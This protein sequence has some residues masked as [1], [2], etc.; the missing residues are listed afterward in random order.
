[1]T[2][3]VQKWIPL[4]ESSVDERTNPAWS[5]TVTTK[6][7]YILPSVRKTLDAF[8]LELRAFTLLV[9]DTEQVIC[10]FL[11]KIS[12]LCFLS[13]ENITEKCLQTKQTIS[14]GHTTWFQ[15]RNKMITTV[16]GHN[17]R[18]QAGLTPSPPSPCAALSLC[19]LDV[20]GTLSY[21]DIDC[22]KWQ[23]RILHT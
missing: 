17:G 6:V 22:C 13:L 20:W 15:E 10:R 14:S 23:P 3:S 2:F 7:H 8:K 16:R 18:W 21:P 1:M 4:K 19:S 12:S 5:L 9:M 11:Y